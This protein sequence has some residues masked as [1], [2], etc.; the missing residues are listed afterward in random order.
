M[1]VALILLLAMAICQV[2]GLAEIFLL[3]SKQRNLNSNSS[4]SIKRLKAYITE[5]NEIIKKL[6]SQIVDSEHQRE[7]LDQ[8]IKELESL[9][10]RLSNDYS[11]IKKEYDGLRKQIVSNDRTAEN[12][13]LLSQNDDLKRETDDEKRKNKEL[14]GQKA[15]L[16]SRITNLEKQ[17]A[18]AQKA[19]NADQKLQIENLSYQLA[20]ALKQAEQVGKLSEKYKKELE[21]KSKEVEKLIRAC[22]VLNDKV[23]ELESKIDLK[24]GTQ[25]NNKDSGEKEKP[26]SIQPYIPGDVKEVPVLFRDGAYQETLGNLLDVIEIKEYVKRSGYEK[27]DMYVRLL[28][29][30]IE[31]LGDAFESINADADEIAT[32]CM[33]KFARC[34]EQYFASAII[35][36]ATRGMEENDFYVKLIEKVYEY[37]K[38]N[39]I[40]SKKINVGDIYENMPYMNSIPKKITDKSKHK[41]IEQVLSLPF[42][43]RYTNEYGKV[44]EKLLCKGA[45]V[46][47]TAK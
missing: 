46:V 43:A 20:E 27:S 42:Y 11:I 33:D 13:Q 6:Q 24:S 14:Q 39:N 35:E 38:K 9:N 1:K 36:S 23:N 29:T 21:L 15:E 12:R 3:V 19:G 47:L 2:A 10:N 7:D 44:K 26:D 16:L 32:L 34:F 17:L 4:E 25:D 8:R 37:L 41:C 31:E 28:D 30:Y 5:L 45:C 40:Y 22:Q 18:E